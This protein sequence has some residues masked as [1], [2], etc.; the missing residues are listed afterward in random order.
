MEVFVSPTFQ[1]AII[2]QSGS[3]AHLSSGLVLM[4]GPKGS[5]KSALLKT[6]KLGNGETKGVADSDPKFHAILDYCY[7]DAIDS[8]GFVETQ[9]DREDAAQTRVSVWSCSN[10]VSA[11]LFSEDI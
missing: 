4:V 11:L 2:P 3:K 10:L 7:F 1:Q 8:M 5:G 6:F 9:A